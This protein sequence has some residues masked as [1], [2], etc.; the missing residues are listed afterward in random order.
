MIAGRIKAKVFPEPVSAIP[1]IS[2]P[3]ITIGHDWH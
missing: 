3:L 2:L 1:T